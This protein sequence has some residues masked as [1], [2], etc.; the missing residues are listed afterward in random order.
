M[1]T[2]DR[3]TA[4]RYYFPVIRSFADKETEKIFK[5]YFS[6]KLPPEIQHAARLKLEILDAAEA[7]QDLRI[8]PSNRLEKLSG[9]RAIQ[10]SIRINKQWRICFEWRED[11]AEN[12]EI[13]DYHG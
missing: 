3:I 11:Y 6:R 12:V 4:R 10:Y 2:F 1:I 5:R 13:V 7:L 8:P 9:D